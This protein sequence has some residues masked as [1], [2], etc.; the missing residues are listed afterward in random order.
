MVEP[1]YQIKW[2]NQYKKDIKLAKK[3]NYKIEE[4]EK[5]VFR[6]ANGLPLP[7]KHHDHTLEGNWIN[8]RECHIKPDCLL[9]TKKN[10]RAA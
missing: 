9:P 5:V 4:L 2:T 7:E 6:L 3:R 10:S 8:H 1:K